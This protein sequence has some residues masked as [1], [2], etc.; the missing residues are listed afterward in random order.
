[1]SMRAKKKNETNAFHIFSLDRSC[2]SR[3]DAAGG[4]RLDLRMKHG[5]AEEAARGHAGDS[6]ARKGRQGEGVEAGRRGRGACEEEL[7]GEG[8]A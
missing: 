5:A 3:F 6:E 8:E 7:D 2:R 4:E 1:M